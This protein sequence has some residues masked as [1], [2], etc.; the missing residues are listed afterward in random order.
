V[1][2]VYVDDK[3]VYDNANSWEINDHIRAVYIERY[4]LAGHKVRFTDDIDDKDETHG[5][6]NVKP[7]RE[8]QPDENWR[9]RPRSEGWRID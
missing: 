4:A 5:P 9:L 6:W 8:I 7:Y 2:Y 3:Y 1:F